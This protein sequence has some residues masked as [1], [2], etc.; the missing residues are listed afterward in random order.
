MSTAADVFTAFVDTLAATLDDHHDGS[1]IAAR[2]HLSRYH[3]DR[4]I[5]AAAGEPP[6]RLRRRILLER[7][8]YRLLSCDLTVLQIAVEAGYSSH[9][10]FTRAF[11]RAYGVAPTRWRAAPRQIQLPSA[12]QV[13]FHPP[14][15]LRLPARNEVT[16]MQLLTK[17]V[18]HHVWLVGEIVDRLDRLDDA[19][20]DTLIRVSCDNED[21]TMSLRS[22]T[23]RLIGQMDMWMCA[24]NN[25]EY[26]WDLEKQEPV[27]S[28]RRRLDHVGPAF[29]AQVQ[30]VVDTGR[31]DDTFIDAL[32][33]P[34]EVFT[35]GGMIAHVL[36]FAAYNRTLV[37]QQLG[38]LGIDDLGWGDPMLWVAQPA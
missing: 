16:P 17:M 26:D 8:A 32:C 1:S 38:E 12:S 23:S 25:R 2:L 18:E 3:L 10:A 15:G 35:Y 11:Q 36:T 6:A 34:P 19:Q 24:I 28:M 4:L 31:L 5:S 37:V 21:G 14:A 29:L 27:A 9:E 22:I 33:D 7:A 20:L 13:H 30:E